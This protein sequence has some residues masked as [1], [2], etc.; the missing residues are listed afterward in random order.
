[1]PKIET[2]N[3]PREKSP[4][5]INREVFADISLKVG[6]YLD[7]LYGSLYML[8]GR[9]QDFAYPKKDW[10]QV[11]KLLT[12]ISEMLSG[13][14][15]KKGIHFSRKNSL[16][17]ILGNYALMGQQM[18]EGRKMQKNISINIPLS[19]G[20]KEGMK[21]LTPKDIEMFR[22]YKKEWDLIL[23][24]LDLI[25]KNPNMLETEMAS[26][27]GW[28][29]EFKDFYNDKKIPI[30][31]VPEKLKHI[32]FFARL[33]SYQSELADIRGLKNLVDPI[34]AENFEAEFSR[35]PKN[36]FLDKEG[37]RKYFLEEPEHRQAA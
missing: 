6:Q 36:E 7:F 32:N 30:M 37:L 8:A 28:L 21:D 34:K 13:L 14:A 12:E 3:L 33:K 31:D 26:E 19:P 24:Y 4:L 35:L 23:Y 15:E 5:E 9:H 22:D 11:E 16:N 1:M 25:E 17:H 10:P 20:A 29:E 18:V 27:E 2:E